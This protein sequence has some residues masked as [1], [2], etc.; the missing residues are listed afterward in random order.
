[1]RGQAEAGDSLR[2]LQPPLIVTGMKGHKLPPVAMQCAGFLAF[3]L[4]FQNGG[5]FV[6]VRPGTRLNAGCCVYASLWFTVY[7]STDC[8]CTYSIIY[9]YIIYI[10]I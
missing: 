1:M 3:W 2:D 5:H 6:D 4:P 9:I 7:G 10:Y 8:I